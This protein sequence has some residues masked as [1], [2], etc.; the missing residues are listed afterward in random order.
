LIIKSYTI[1]KQTRF[2]MKTFHCVYVPIVH[3]SD[4]RRIKY[5]CEIFILQIQPWSAWDLRNKMQSFQPQFFASTRIGNV[6]L[7]L[8]KSL[9]QYLDSRQFIDKF[10]LLNSY[11]NTQ[12]S[13]TFYRCRRVSRNWSLKTWLI[14]P[15]WSLKI[16]LTVCNFNFNSLHFDIVTEFHVFVSYIP[17]S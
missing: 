8:Y 13:G 4:K 3:W 17:R 1:K 5:I 6:L 12:S 10:R 14:D 11:R 9:N 2:C 15:S 7:L 16:Y